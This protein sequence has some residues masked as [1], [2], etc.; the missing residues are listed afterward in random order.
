M[1]GTAVLHLDLDAF[2][3]SV[4]QL[5]NPRLRGRPVIVGAGCIASCS[6]EARRHGL[7]AG[8]PMREAKRLCPGAVVLDGHAQIYRCFAEAVFDIAL[9][10]SPS[11]ET[12]LDEAY[13][14]LSGM[15]SLYPRGYLDAGRRLQAEVLRAVGLPV[16]IGIGSNRMIAKMVTRTVKP[17]GVGECAPGGEEAFIPGRPVRDL[18]GVG[19]S[20]ERIL[21][22]LNIH[23]I[24]DLRR[25]PEEALRELFGAPGAQLY[26]RCRG[27]DTAVISQRE[28]PG[29]IRR[30]TSFHT[31]TI[32]PAEMEGMLHYLCSRAMHEMRRLGLSART[33]RVHL[34]YEDME[35]EARSQ[36][37][38]A[39]TMLDEEI[40]GRARGILRM[41]FTRR[42]AVRNIGIEL[43]R[44]EA[45]AGEQLDLFDT[46][47]P[48]AAYA[49]AG[50]RVRLLDLEEALDRV[51]D[52]YGFASVTGG[53]S[54]DL[55]SRLERD[56]HGF[57]LRTPSLTR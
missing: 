37:L 55:L 25:V 8:M 18:P 31:P 11:I 3:A 17:G 15:R 40:F 35:G 16:S 27:M 43:S 52:R 20:T 39:P 5:R 14:D 48:G 26:Q 44:F 47:A 34:R 32:D 22:G 24:D 46:P 13:L 54:L 42:M 7:S 1:P 4:E 12:F 29:S 41:L 30:E 56:R 36:T 19:H 57:I 38:A 21:H 10:F 23:T 51:R 50:C 28:I 53:A 2:F 9:R 45:D 6:Y 49:G 33:F